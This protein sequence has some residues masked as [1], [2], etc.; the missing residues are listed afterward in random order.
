[1]RLSRIVLARSNILNDS[2]PWLARSF[3]KYAG[4]WWSGWGLVVP[5]WKIRGY[6]A[7]VSIG[8]LQ[9]QQGAL[10][11]IIKLTSNEQAQPPMGQRLGPASE[12]VISS[13]T[14]PATSPARS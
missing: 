12:T 10:S 14:T 8:W 1:M 13:R 11:G 3:G 6:P 2:W 7:I 4:V 9:C 5:F